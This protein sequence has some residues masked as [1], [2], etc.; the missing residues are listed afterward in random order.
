[1]GVGEGAK[2]DKKEEP[3]VEEG[4]TCGVCVCTAEH[5]LREARLRRAKITLAAAAPSP[6]ARPRCPPFGSLRYI[7]C[8]FD[9]PREIS[10][11]QFMPF[12]FSLGPGG[13]GKL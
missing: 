6:G 11:T 10:R 4:N 5:V 13:R 12:S 1:M 2:G 8:N 3:S 9:R 7:F